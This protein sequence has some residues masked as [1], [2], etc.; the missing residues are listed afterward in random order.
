MALAAYAYM[1]R[2]LQD[3][4][5]EQ[6]A[7]YCESEEASWFRNATLK[8]MDLAVYRAASEIG[9]RLAPAGQR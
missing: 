3:E 5:L 6:L 2:S 8:G 4:E 7:T 9:Q 1:F